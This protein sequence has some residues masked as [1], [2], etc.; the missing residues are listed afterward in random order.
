MTTSILF[1]VKLKDAKG[2]GQDLNSG[3]GYVSWVQNI[4]HTSLGA[5][6][7]HEINL[8]FLVAII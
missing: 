4:Y 5:S 6:S 8:H 7:P 1:L 3:I 2:G